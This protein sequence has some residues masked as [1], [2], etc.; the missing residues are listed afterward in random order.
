MSDNS[1]WMG[2]LAMMTSAISVL[3]YRADSAQR[4]C[5]S[6]RSELWR[7]VYDLSM[8]RV[9]KL[10]ASLEGTQ[11]RSSSLSPPQPPPPE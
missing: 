1:L 5:E 9:P 6:D 10:P 11:P 8:G 4:K 3:Y 7:A 2:I